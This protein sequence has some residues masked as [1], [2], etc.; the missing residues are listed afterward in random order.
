[1]LGL[2][3]LGHGCLAAGGGVFVHQPALKCLVYRLVGGCQGCGIALFGG[4]DTLK[5]PAEG[6]AAH[7]VRGLFAEALAVCFLCRLGN[8]HARSVLY[9][10]MIGKLTGLVAQSSPGEAIVDVGGVGYLVR[11]PL[12]LDLPEGSPVSLNIYTAVRDDA[13]DLYGFATAQD[14]AFFKQ[15]MTV[16][17]IGPKTALGIMGVS[18]IATL[19][20]H[21]AAGDASALTKIF[22]IGKKSAERIA[23]ELKDKVAADTGAGAGGSDLMDALIAL[24]YSATEAR[25]ALKQVGGGDTKEQLHAAL[26]Y[27]GNH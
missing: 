17:S 22:G 7:V 11:T 2:K 16:S 10:Y 20:R 26:K 27:L 6:L 3:G 1:M 14:M 25:Q 8:C 24:G 13:I 21:I 4:A 5:S 15:L 19:K 12:S 18:D 23:L 9:K